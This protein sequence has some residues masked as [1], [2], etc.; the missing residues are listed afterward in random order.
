MKALKDLIYTW[1]KSETIEDLNTNRE[2]LYNRLKAPYRNY[3]NK[4]WRL[5]ERRVIRFYTR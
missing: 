3:I 1:I 4:E 2:A 5:K